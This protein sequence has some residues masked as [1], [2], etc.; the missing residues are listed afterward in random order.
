MP[1]PEQLDERFAD[2][3]D[4]RL[5]DEERAELEATLAADPELAQRFADYRRTVALIRPSLAARAPLDLA[6]VVMANAGTGSGGTVHAWSRWTGWGAVAATGLLAI[7]LWGVWRDP[8]V[9]ADSRETARAPEAGVANLDKA[10]RGFGELADRSEDLA[11]SLGR[12][13]E[14][15]TAGASVR[16][17]L[18]AAEERVARFREQAERKQA[19]GGRAQTQTLAQRQLRL[20]SP[21]A[22]EAP[23][24][25]AEMEE[26]QPVGVTAAESEPEGAAPSSDEFFV[27]GARRRA[28]VAPVGD[29]GEQGKD[30]RPAGTPP[31]PEAPEIVVVDVLG[32]FLRAPSEQSEPQDEQQ[33]IGLKL[34]LGET[35]G[36]GG[37]GGWL[38]R[39]QQLAGAGVSVSPLQVPAG[40]DALRVLRFDNELDAQLPAPPATVGLDVE[41]AFVERWRSTVRPGDWAFEVS[42]SRDA[43]QNYLTAVRRQLGHAE[44]LS[45]SAQQRAFDDADARAA[46]APSPPKTPPPETPPPETPRSE[47]P[48]PGAAAAPAPPVSTPSRAWLIL[49]PTQAPPADEGGQREKR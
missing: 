21:A 35:V 23:A 14:S 28:R 29:A 33:G 34:K 7:A 49:R 45:F 11:R 12:A 42:G 16:E 48:R 47:T 2:Y 22:P 18:A 38:P 44:L 20:E 24:V 39:L 46:P 36:V 37:G 8:L 13:G 10:E 40:R 1:P 27:G 19:E 15:P 30:L 9:P 5:T 4:D 17:E 26:P 41:R 31:V 25:P 3:L 6:D 43:L 32:A